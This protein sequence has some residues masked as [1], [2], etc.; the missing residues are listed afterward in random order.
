MHEVLKALKQDHLYSKIIGKIRSKTFI[1]SAIIL[2]LLPLTVSINFRLPFIIAFFIDL[3]G[4]IVTLSFVV[5]KNKKVE[6][7]ELKEDNFIA[8]L[9]AGK[10]LRF[11]PILTLTSFISAMVIGASIYRDVYQQFLGISVIH[12]GFFF[13]MSRVVAAVVS[14]YFYR[15]H[16]VVS[17]RTYL[18][19][20]VLFYS[21]FIIGIGFASNKWFV[22]IGFV[23]MVG[24]LH[25]SATLLDHYK[26]EYIQKSKFKATL[27]SIGGLGR[28][29]FGV[30]TNLTLAFL[31]GRYL[32]SLGYVYYGLIGL[33]VLL[34][35]YSVF[36]IWGLPK[37]HS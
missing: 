3:T 35:I 12:L 32:Y 16:N 15:L 5:P 20:A 31:I 8:V 26:L 13:A 14:N 33:V 30:F 1:V 36:I 23:I 18:A 19:I 2:A 37:K 27:L 9:K 28:S 22:A 11:Y 7:E 6:I 34:S 24:S 10:K 29:L 17:A 4:L 21:L 25:G